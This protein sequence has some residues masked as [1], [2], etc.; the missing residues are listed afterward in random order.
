VR[1]VYT[2]DLST[3]DFILDRAEQAQQDL[4]EETTEIVDD[5]LNSD[6]EE[7]ELEL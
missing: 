1:A 5:Y 7:S 6:S 3:G 2:G 4:I